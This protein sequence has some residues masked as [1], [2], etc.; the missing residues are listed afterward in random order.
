M[1]HEAV[2]YGGPHLD[3]PPQRTEGVDE[4][5]GPRLS[6]LFAAATT[7][8]LTTHPRGV[9]V[10]LGA[11]V[12]RA[13]LRCADDVVVIDAPRTEDRRHLRALTVGP[14][15]PAWM[16]AVDGAR[17]LLISAQGLLIHHAAEDVRG[18]VRAALDRFVGV[19]LL[20]DTVPRWLSRRSLRG[21]GARPLPWG[22]DDDEL[23][24]TLS[25]WSSYVTD[26]EVVPYGLG[27]PFRGL[28]ARMFGVPDRRPSFVRVRTWGAT[29]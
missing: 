29:R 10:E 28:L 1:L 11:G 23:P 22:I 4:P 7:S 13:A 25:R 24:G 21:A 27:R 3:A 16:N 14:F 8:W 2:L 20:F 5:G 12:G 6:R 9:V 17:G 26:V 18:L 19:E 15:D